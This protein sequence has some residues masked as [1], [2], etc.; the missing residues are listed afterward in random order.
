[1]RII[2][3]IAAALLAAAGCAAG[4]ATETSSLD[5]HSSELGAGWCNEQPVA[6]AGL[7]PGLYVEEPFI[8]VVG[9]T[10]LLY[11]SDH[12]PGELRD[13]HHAVWI[14]NLG[15][16]YRGPLQNVNTAPFIEGA[17]SV[18]AQGFIYYT[19]TAL[20]GMI[21]RG[22]LVQPELV[23]LPSPIPGMPAMIQLGGLVWGNMDLGV[24]PNHPFGVLS[25]ALWATPSSVPIE[26]DLWYLR[27]SGGSVLHDPNET[28]YFLGALNTT[29][30]LEY[31]AELSADGLAIVYTQLDPAAG[32]TRVMGA[33]RAHVTLP[34]GPPAEIVGNGPGTAIEGPTLAGNRIFFHKIFLAGA[35]SQLYTVERCGP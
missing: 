14:P 20:P 18:D 29:A 2:E 26:A 15:F 19:N 21:G 33:I 11:F 9:T 8:R 32:A 7:P 22:W 5:E 4:C 16:I 23:A 10:T 13:L 35:P 34:F 12:G 6:I 30:R 3:V 1:M 17:P 27:R 25:R 31:A 24:A 28:L